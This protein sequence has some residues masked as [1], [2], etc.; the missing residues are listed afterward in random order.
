LTKRAQ[1]E[2]PNYQRATTDA[3]ADSRRNLTLNT[4]L[5]ALAATMNAAAG[6][7]LKKASPT[8]AT[9]AKGV[10][11]FG[12]VEDKML[13][14]VADE[15]IMKDVGKGIVPCEPDCGPVYQPE[16]PAEDLARYPPAEWSGSS[17]GD[18]L[19]CQAA[20]VSSSPAANFTRGP[21]PSPPPNPAAATC[22]VLT[23][24]SFT[25][26]FERSG[27]ACGFGGCQYDLEQA[28]FA[29]SAPL[30][31]NGTKG[32]LGSGTGQYSGMD[33]HELKSTFSCSSKE[34]RGTVQG[35]SDL[36]V[37]AFASIDNLVTGGIDTSAMPRDTSVIEVMFESHDLHQDNYSKDGCDKPES[38]SN[39]EAAAGVGCYFY[40][41]DLRRPGF[42]TVHLNND[43]SSGICTLRLSR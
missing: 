29:G 19:V 20:P 35:K 28:Q 34:S 16:P 11:Y 38:W 27:S 40:G 9:M 32:Y 4:A 13:D 10:S 25:Y 18:G 23:R 24:A 33:S 26:L 7:M 1:R 17:T 31:V 2:D 30:T 21:T 5:S 43:P 12:K 22:G 6:E 8:G 15:Y 39:N 3:L 36:I 14:H 37:N 41:A 42:Y